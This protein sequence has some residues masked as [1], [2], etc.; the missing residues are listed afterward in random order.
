MGA[1]LGGPGVD[2]AIERLRSGRAGSRYQRTRSGSGGRT[3]HDG[4]AD[5]EVRSDCRE[6]GK[7]DVGGTRRE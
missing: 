1:R 6:P 7:R 5:G 3:G 2:H 4:R